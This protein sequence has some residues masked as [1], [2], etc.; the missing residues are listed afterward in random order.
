MR[1]QA[2]AL[3]V[4]FTPT[5]HMLGRL[6][7]PLAEAPVPKDK[8]VSNEAVVLRYPPMPDEYAES[9]PALL[10]GERKQERY[11]DPEV[12]GGKIALIA[13]KNNEVQKP[14]NSLDRMHTSLPKQVAYNLRA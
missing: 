1:Y 3:N 13:T 14:R 2:N 9:S 5:V 10:F 4:W 8:W 6:D 7:K 11:D 12:H